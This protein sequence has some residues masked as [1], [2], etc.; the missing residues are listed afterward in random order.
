MAGYGSFMYRRYRR[1]TPS[2]AS[3]ILFKAHTARRTYAN[4][5]SPATSERHDFASTRWYSVGGV[6]ATPE[7]HARCTPRSFNCSNVTQWPRRKPRSDDVRQPGLM[8][9]DLPGQSRPQK[10]LQGSQVIRL[11]SQLFRSSTRD[12]IRIADAV[13][14]RW[15]RTKRISIPFFDISLSS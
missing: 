10:V 3:P 12:L 9:Q 6:N 7:G 14:E 11:M 13:L 4:P 2:C 1:T 8:G 15:S 5:C